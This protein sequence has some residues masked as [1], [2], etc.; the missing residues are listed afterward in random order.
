MIK[1][2]ET[3]P[4]IN[5]KKLR[6]KH[7]MNGMKDWKEQYKRDL[8]DLKLDLRHQGDSIF[9]QSPILADVLRLFSCGMGI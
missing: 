3:A 8:S 5:T 4:I 7:E 1:K 6:S 9:E 2:S